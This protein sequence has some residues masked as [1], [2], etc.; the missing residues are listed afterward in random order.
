METRPFDPSGVQTGGEDLTYIPDS[1]P[2]GT[3]C[4]RGDSASYIFCTND[5]TCEYR[6]LSSGKKGFRAWGV[7]GTLNW[8]VASRLQEVDVQETLTRLGVVPPYLA[9]GAGL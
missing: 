7:S 5:W 3:Q 4:F 8:A 9:V 2:E 6:T 1:F